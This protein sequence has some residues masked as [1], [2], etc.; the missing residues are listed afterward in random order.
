MSLID[1]KEGF[2]VECRNC[3]DKLSIKYTDVAALYGFR[4]LVEDQALDFAL[5][6]CH[7]PEPGSEAEH[8]ASLARNA[9][10]IELRPG[11]TLETT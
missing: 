3:G 2:R 6:D 1:P 9:I 10:G 7:Q 11:S 5:C 4:S 8:V